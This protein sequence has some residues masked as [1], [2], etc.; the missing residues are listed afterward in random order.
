MSEQSSFS[1]IKLAINSHDH[2]Q[3]APRRKGS[4]RE[5]LKSSVGLLAAGSA[6]ETLSKRAFAQN[7]SGSD[8]DAE[9]ARLGAERRILL[10]GGIV[11]T[12]DRQ[13]GDFA[14]ADVLIEDGKIREIRPNIT[15]TGDYVQV[16][17][18]S[19]R[20][21]IPGFIDTHSHSYEGIH[22]QQLLPN[23]HHR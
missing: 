20:I 21:L 10:K 3:A 14:E 12:L 1:E 18:A 13:I 15:T 4:R 2:Q 9:L 8:A 5:F 23:V 6:T 7:S 22:A 16:I 17:D 19:N 11:L